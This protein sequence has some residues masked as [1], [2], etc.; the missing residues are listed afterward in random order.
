MRPDHQAATRASAL[1]PLQAWWHTRST[2]ERQGLWAAALL[3]ACTLCWAT[4]VAPA[5]RILQQAPAEHRRLDHLTAEMRTLAEE[6]TRLRAEPVAAAEG[7]SAALQAAS[8][9]LARRARL[10][11]KGDRA[12][13][14]LDG[15]SLDELGPWL[16]ELRSGA[17]TRPLEMSL[18]RSPGG[19]SGTLVLA[20]PGKP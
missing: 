4:L 16:Q 11:L 5:W 3:L 17:R 1:A 15:L 14:Q 9:R 2:R 20:L 10:T 6:A 13:F 18:T 8:T 12:V 19:Y 7:A